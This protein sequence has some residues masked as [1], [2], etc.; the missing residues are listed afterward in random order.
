[1]TRTV[2][3]SFLAVVLFLLVDGSAAQTTTGSISGT[4]L[5][6]S[7]L[8]P[9]PG[10]N[11]LLID[12]NIGASADVEGRF[13]IS[14]V[15][16]GTYQLRFSA[17]GRK[18]VL[19]ADV[20]VAAARDVNL[21]V[22][23]PEVAIDLE[24][25][26]VRASFFQKTPDAPVSVQRL[27]YEE[28]RRSPGGFEDVLRA[29]AV[30]PGVAQAAP[31]R[32]DLVVRGGAPS[33][34]LYVIDNIEIPNINHFGTQGASGGP[35]SYISLDFVRETAFSTGGFGVRY[36]DRMSSV[37]TIDLQDGRKDAVGGK[38]TISA[39]QFGLNLQGP[40][41][42]NASFIFSARRSYLDLIFRAAG[43]SFVPEY[44][45]FLGRVSYKLDPSNTLSFLAVGAIDD[46]SFFN[47]DADARF[48]NSRVLGTA[49]R[50]YVSGLTWQHLLGSGF[51]RVTLGRTFSN[52]NGIQRDSLLNPVFT[53]RAKEGET[54]LRADVVLKPARLTE[55]SFGSQLKRV[56]FS[57]TLALDGFETTFGDTLSVNIRGL[58]STGYKASGY[59]QVAQRLFDD[60]ELTLGGR[61]DHFS[62]IDVGTYFSPRGSLT[63][64]VTPLTT[65]GFSAGV[66][67]QNPSYIWLVASDQNTSLRAA[68][69]DQYILSAEH[70]LDADLRIRLEGFHKRYTDYPASIDRPYLV[71]A[72][73]GGGFGG[74][75]E[76]FAAFGLDRLV[77]AGKGRSRGVELL[78]QKKLSRVPLYGL[79][80]LTFM[81]TTFVALDGVERPGAFDQRTIINLS[82]GYRFDERWET[83]L[84]FRF[85]TGQPY[86][87]FT[88]NGA[89]DIAAF[90]SLRLTNSHSLDLRVDRRWNFAAWNLIVYVDVQNVY[91]NKFSGVPRWN[92]RQQRAEF[93]ERSI[94]LLPSIGVS[95]EF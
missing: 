59:V 38:G 22:R 50:Q 21:V 52:Y 85:S 79:A 34:N 76:N 43:F 94:G 86:T 72:N 15:P 19:I 46:V 62:L 57:T 68:R 83:S 80:S 42:N 70:L 48:D 25:V 28:I 1:M 81:Q 30:L 44:W 71:L 26:E 33:E 16:V 91:N 3:T 14:N 13:R 64:S 29:V 63:Y 89:Q 55:L 73:T 82:A 31:G 49:Q 24:A 17:V 20:V 74:A 32:N 23:L 27:S 88:S 6:Q 92:A 90:N 5:G 56:R 77:S 18:P 9:I 69:A 10:A 7:T 51:S 78:V 95:A 61:V 8:E 60:F 39:S 41:G 53:N 65:L 87:P 36:G 12:T 2:H 11:I 37:L 93:S 58:T 54:S 35:L 67:R 45:D 84:K 4:V 66:Y 40:L 47:D 75:D